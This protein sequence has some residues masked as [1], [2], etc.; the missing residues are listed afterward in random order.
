MLGYYGK[1]VFVSIAFPLLPMYNIISL[2]QIG[3]FPT[4]SLLLSQLHLF[5]FI[6]LLCQWLFH[7]ICACTWPVSFVYVWRNWNGII[8]SSIFLLRG[9]N[10]QH[11]SEHK[12]NSSP[13]KS[14]Q[15]G[16]VEK[17]KTNNKENWTFKSTILIIW[18]EIRT[19]HGDEI[20]GGRKNKG[21]FLLFLLMFSGKRCYC[22]VDWPHKKAYVHHHH[23]TKLHRVV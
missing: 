23:T 19:L 12:A 11:L 18:I 13:G 15:D 1:P 7:F 2:F 9:R 14:H 22:E 17:T 8:V 16:K 21:L 10:D 4:L 5:H 20:E 6:S 3:Y